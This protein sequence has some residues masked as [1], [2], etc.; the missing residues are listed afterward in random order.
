MDNAS[1][2]IHVF[3]DRLE[4]RLLDRFEAAA[5]AEGKWT[6]NQS[7]LRT[8]WVCGCWVSS[9]IFST[10]SQFH[11]SRNFFASPSDQALS[12]MVPSPC[13]RCT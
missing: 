3:A 4:K 9:E 1:K 2:N 6:C 5:M 8:E 7:V 11:L 12:A 10:G 13:R